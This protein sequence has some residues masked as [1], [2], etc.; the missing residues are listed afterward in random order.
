MDKNISFLLG[1]EQDQN[2]RTVND[3]LRFN[4]NDWE[5]QHDV[6]QMAFPTKTQS[7]FH[8]NQPFLSADFDI[9]ALDADQ[10]QRCKA[11]VSLLLHSYLKSL[12]VSF[13]I[14]HDLVDIHFGPFS[15]GRPYWTLPRDH[16]TLRLTRVLECLGIFEMTN[17]QSA[18]YDFLVY[19]VIPCYSEGIDSYTL[20]HW[21]AAKD[22]KL[23]LLR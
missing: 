7:K 5:D 20:A 17:I 12:S 23:H 9:N 13:L 14:N 1:Y 21:V 22:N 6:I 19:T 10:K 8:P 18:L 11:T 3:Y 16:N 2:T 15:T 4:E